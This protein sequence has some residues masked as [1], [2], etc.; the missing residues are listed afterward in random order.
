MM[1]DDDQVSE[2]KIKGIVETVMLKHL[3]PLLEQAISA[4]R[5]SEMTTGGGKWSS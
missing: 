5:S 2:D 4:T 1:A 3:Q